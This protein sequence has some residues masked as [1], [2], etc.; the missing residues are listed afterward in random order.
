MQSSEQ[1]INNLLLTFVI[2]I[3]KVESEDKNYMNNDK[4]K[5]STEIRKYFS[6]N[7]SLILVQQV[8]CEEK[9]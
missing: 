9:N 7:L 5:P 6:L 4:E 2:S 8:A 1:N 3:N